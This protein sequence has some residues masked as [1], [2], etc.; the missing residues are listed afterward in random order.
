MESVYSLSGSPSV[1]DA[2][3]GRINVSA[4]DGEAYLIGYWRDTKYAL[5]QV[6]GSLN[7]VIK[8]VEDRLGNKIKLDYNEEFEQWEGRRFSSICVWACT[9]SH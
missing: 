7:E 3:L 5:V 2:I 4:L 8:L 1:Y 6:A 9:I